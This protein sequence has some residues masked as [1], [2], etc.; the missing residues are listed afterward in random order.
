MKNLSP[1]DGS[2]TLAV[3][4]IAAAMAALCL[5]A[6]AVEDGQGTNVVRNLRVTGSASVATNLTVGDAV[7]ADSV[8]ANR[9]TAYDSMTLNGQQIESWS[10]IVSTNSAD[11]NAIHKTDSFTGHGDL[12]GTYNGNDIVIKN[13]AVTTVKILDANVTENKLATDAVT[14][15]KIKDANVTEGKIADGAVTANKIGADAVTTGKILDANVTENKLATDAVTTIKIKDANV[16]EGKIA[17]GA[18]T[19]IKIK[20]AN[21]TSAKM[22]EAITISSLTVTNKQVLAQAAEQIVAA[23]G[24]ITVS[25]PFVPIKGSGGPVSATIAAGTTAGQTLILRGI[26]AVNTVRITNNPPLVVLAE[27]VNFTMGTNDILQVVY[28]GQGW[29]EVHRADN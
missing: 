10:D 14:T 15:I 1:I 12:N 27:G 21:V 2:R 16:T 7:S 13:D 26:D 28:S 18:V 22:A 20:D 4:I 19:T 6:L 11:T 24:A 17:D 3:I 5:P 25:S 29:V 23:D 8:T 9:V